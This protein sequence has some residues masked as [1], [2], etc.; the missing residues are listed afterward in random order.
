MKTKKQVIEEKIEANQEEIYAMEIVRDLN[1][2][3]DHSE[4]KVQVD[5]ANDRIKKCEV[6]LTFLKE[7]LRIQD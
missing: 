3:S 7:Y 2:T 1:I 6:Q 4:A 5:A